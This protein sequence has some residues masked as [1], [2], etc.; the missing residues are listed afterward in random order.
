MGRQEPGHRAAAGHRGEGPAPGGPAHGDHGD[1]LHAGAEVVVDRGGADVEAA[2]H[3]LLDLHLHEVAARVHE[4]GRSAVDAQVQLRL[5]HVPHEEPALEVGADHRAA[6]EVGEDA[7][8]PV[9]GR[10][11]AGRVRVVEAVLGRVRGVRVEVEDPQTAGV[12]GGVEQPVLHVAVVRDGR[13]AVRER[14]HVEGVVGVGD[15]DHVRRR[16]EGAVLVQL[17]AHVEVL[18]VL[19]EPALVAVGAVG[20]VDLADHLRVRLVGD[21]DDRETGVATA[22]VEPRTAVGDLAACVRPRGVGHHLSVVDV[23]RAPGPDVL[24]AGRVGEAV[25]AQAVAAAAG[26]VEEA[27][28]LVDE[29][30]VRVGGADVI[31]DARE[32][33][34][35]AV[36]V[37][38]AHHLDAAAALGD[39]VRVLVVDLDVTPEAAGSRDVADLLRVRGHGDVEESRAARRAHDPVLASARADVAPAVV[40]AARAV[41]LVQRDLGLEGHVAGAHERVAARAR[42]AAG[43][44]GQPQVAPDRPG[45][46]ALA[47]EDLGVVVV[48]GDG[49]GAEHGGGEEQ[50]ELHGGSRR[51]GGLRSRSAESFRRYP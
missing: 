29:D 6:R 8:E 40:P 36:D 47:V 20:P 30:V 50:V 5:T 26:P 22:T 42:D 39:D 2:G 28:V 38:Q 44:A 43:A 24:R 25:H 15:V 37:G 35:A 31:D 4:V 32:R 10:A 41:D 19:A 17:V 9:E 7:P 48:E 3:E 49:A 45:E 14:G 51:H 33:D 1:G 18:A 21:V 16:G 12:V 46:G 23:A 11:V 27:R 34:L 13:V